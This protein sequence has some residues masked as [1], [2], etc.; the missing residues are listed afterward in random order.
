MR[1]FRLGEYCFYA[2]LKGGLEGRGGDD[3]AFEGGE[4]VAAGDVRGDEQEDD[5][6]DEVGES[7]A[8]FAELGAVGF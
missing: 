3:H 1:D 2:F 6:G 8:V 4:V 5:G 7:G